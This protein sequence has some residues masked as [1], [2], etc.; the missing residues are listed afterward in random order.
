MHQSLGSQL[1]DNMLLALGAASLQFIVQILII[2]IIIASQSMNRSP[3]DVHFTEEK[4]VLKV[5]F[6]FHP[7]DL[8]NFT[9][10]SRVNDKVASFAGQDQYL[11]FISGENVNFVKAKFFKDS[12]WPYIEANCS[13]YINKHLN[14]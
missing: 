3:V 2:V 4:D 11:S 12:I 9:L 14:I 7:K 8:Q 1:S 6:T 10:S 13:F 5:N